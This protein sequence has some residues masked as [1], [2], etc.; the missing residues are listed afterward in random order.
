M[1]LAQLPSTSKVCTGIFAATDRALSQDLWHDRWTHALVVAVRAVGTV[2][3]AD[4]ANFSLHV[5]RRGKF[6]FSGASWL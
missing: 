2:K 5:K 6:A 4:M 1:E 3:R